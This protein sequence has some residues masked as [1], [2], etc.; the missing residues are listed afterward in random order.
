[1]LAGSKSFYSSP[2]ETSK[3][4]DVSTESKDG[5][6]VFKLVATAEIDD[7]EMSPSVENFPTIFERDCQRDQ[8][9]RDQG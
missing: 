6:D 8:A 9:L 5:L 3:D 1:M 2:V 4:S 7:D